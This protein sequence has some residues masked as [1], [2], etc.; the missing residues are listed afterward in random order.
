MCRR[1]TAGQ[2]NYFAD[3]AHIAYIAQYTQLAHIALRCVAQITTSP[4]EID[5]AI[6]QSDRLDLCSNL[7]FPYL[8]YILN[9]TS[10]LFSLASK[11]H[12][13]AIYVEKGLLHTV[14]LTATCNICIALTSLAC[15]GC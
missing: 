12:Q 9:L 1:M 15:L 10:E 13:N 6:S 7:A 2:M 14:V 8:Q 3:I 5:C 4:L 11:Y